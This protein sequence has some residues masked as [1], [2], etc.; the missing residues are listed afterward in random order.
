[1]DVFSYADEHEWTELAVIEWAYEDYSYEE[2][3]VWRDDNTE[4]FYMAHDSGCSC[5]TP[6]GEHDETDIWGPYTKEEALKY[7]LERTVE[8]LDDIRAYNEDARNWLTES[9]AKLVQRILL[10]D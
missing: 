3:V 9:S 2:T 10:G 5:P 6:F 7:V 8:S 1:M 4:L